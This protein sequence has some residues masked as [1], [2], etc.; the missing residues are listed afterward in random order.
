MVIVQV[1]QRIQCGAI[2]QCHSRRWVFVVWPLILDTYWEV[3]PQANHISAYNDRKKNL[4]SWNL[5]VC[6]FVRARVCMWMLNCR[7]PLELHQCLFSAEQTYW[8]LY[9][10]H[11]LL[12]KSMLK[13]LNYKCKY[14]YTFHIFLIILCW[15]IVDV[16][17]IYNL[18][19]CWYF[20]YFLF[21]LK[22]MDRS[23]YK[24]QR[25]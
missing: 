22:W 10:W 11:W 17:F 4:S 12:K 19:N 1:R 23:C 2:P 15:N 16:C 9:G 3:S 20:I 13:N 7:I 18:R 14:V 8:R 25:F 21:T 24:P 5:C 6:V